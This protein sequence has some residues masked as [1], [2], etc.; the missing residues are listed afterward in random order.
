[1][2]AKDLSNKIFLPPRRQDT[3]FNPQISQITR[4]TL[5]TLR[6]IRNL[7]GLIPRSLP[8]GGSFIINIY[9]CVLVPLWLFFP[10]YP[11]WV[12]SDMRPNLFIKNKSM[13]EYLYAVF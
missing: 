2:F 10:V 7:Q 6:V 9:F 5:I 1:M 12:V 11:G 4:I 8:R 3:K 13:T